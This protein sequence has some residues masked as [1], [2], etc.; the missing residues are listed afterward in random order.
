MPLTKV[1]GNMQ[2]KNNLT[3]VTKDADFSNKIL[4]HTPPPKAINIRTGNM[5]MKN[6][7]SF[8]TQIWGDVLVIS[9]TNKLVTVFRDKIEAIT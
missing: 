4:L 5:A 7:H 3:I 2:K 1:F 6:F 8:I 9:Q